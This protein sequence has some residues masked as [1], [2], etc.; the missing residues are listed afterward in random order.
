M[1]MITVPTFVKIKLNAL[2]RL[3]RKSHCNGKNPVRMS[4]GPNDQK[5]WRS[6]NK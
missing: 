5:T 3:H 2:E 6:G 4:C 1:S